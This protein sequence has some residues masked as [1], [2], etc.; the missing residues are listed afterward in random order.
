MLLDISPTLKMYEQTD[1]KFALGYWH[2][3]FL[4]QPAPLP[5][6]LIGADPQG[7]ME[8]F[9]IK[10]YAGRTVF[11]PEN[12]A[13]YLEGIKDP[14]SL[15]AMCE[16]YRASVTIDLEHDRA[17]RAKGAKLSQPLRVLWGQHGMIE[18]CFD[19]IN[20]WLE[21]AQSVSGRVLDAGH[22]LPEEQPQEV[23]QE[24]RRFFG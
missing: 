10:R 11:E 24:I 15:H 1:M 4:V 3:F 14:A 19:P 8:S 2:W 17:D 5:E 22:Y 7:F 9:M 18:R 23:A 21:V 16:D 6:Q 13:Q 12:W 20:D